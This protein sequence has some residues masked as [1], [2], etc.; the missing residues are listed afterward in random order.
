MRSILHGLTRADLRSHPF[1]HVAV[2]G[3]VEPE[4][5]AELQAALPPADKFLR[6]REAENNLPY[7]C[8]AEQLLAD[9]PPVWQEFARVHTSPEFFAEVVALFGD[10]IRAL[11]PAL[12]AR[13]G[14]PLEEVR[15]SVRF[16][17]PFADVALDCQLT[18]G[19]PVTRASRAHRVHVDRQV[20]LYAGLL[21]F[22]Q[23][24]DDSV[25]G[26]LELYRFRGDT[27]VYDE[28]R[29]VEDA[30]VERVT[31]VPYAAN[32]LVFFV[33]SPAA[34]HGVSVREVTPWPRLHVNFLAEFPERFWELPDGTFRAAA[35]DRTDGTYRTDRTYGT[36]GAPTP[37]ISPMSPISPTAPGEGP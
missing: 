18:W 27:R 26:D 19:A 37:P 14:K 33:H 23:P 6:G 3:A 35:P 22:R 11:H 21:Y 25:G 5:Y 31:T 20:A 8:S 24:G 16:A 15:T 36:D 29:F 32:R 1:P 34:L 17:E 2:D 10:T 4:L 9:G 30:L 28:G 13:L 12:E 7:R